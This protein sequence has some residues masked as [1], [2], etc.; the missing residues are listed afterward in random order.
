MLNIYPHYIF[1]NKVLNQITVRKNKLWRYLP[2]NSISLKGIDAIP[3]KEKL[4]VRID[5]MLGAFQK[6]LQEISEKEKKLILEQANEALSHKFV[7]LGSSLTDMNRINWHADFKTGYIWP[8]GVYY[9]KQRLATAPGSDIKV[10][11]E[12]SRFHHLLWLGEAYVLTE[13]DK[14]A[15]EIVAEID[16]W[17]RENPLMYSVNWTCTMDVAIRAVNWL[18]SV[19]MIL[20]S[21][22]VSDTF[23]EKFYKSLYQHGWFIYN[24][25]EKSVP[26]SNN[27]LF[28]D[29]SGLIYLAL[30]FENTK[31]GKKWKKYVVPEFYEEI[32][33]QILPS[34]VQYERSVSY[35]RLMTELAS[36]PCYLLKRIGH[37]IPAD[38]EYRV[39]SMYSFIATYTKD[40]GYAP[41]IEDNDDG[42]FLP[43]LRRDFRFHDYLLDSGSVE[44]RVIAKGVPLFRYEKSNSRLYKDAGHAII[45]KSEAY[46]FVTN[47]GFSKYENDLKEQGSHTHND[48]LSFELSLGM[49]DII[50]DPGAYVYTSDPEKCNEF[51]ST[52]KHNTIVVDG[53]EQNELSRENVFLL[54]KN[55]LTTSFEFETDGACLGGYRTLKQSMSH[56]R[57]LWLKED[58]LIVK[59]KLEKP[60]GGHKAVL[61]FHLSPDVTVQKV[62]D[63]VLIESESYSVTMTF[64]QKESCP[65]VIVEDDTYSPSYGVLV[66]SKTIRIVHNFEESTQIETKIQWQK[67][68]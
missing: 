22:E 57:K 67:K 23:I 64:I 53:E 33:R 2:V 40:N 10:P 42:R 32:R 31:R 61:S 13:E 54:R 35:H 36:Y 4:R 44:N 56:N 21:S 49:D 12:L 68:K 25:L 66:S 19:A 24:N 11:W 3:T 34:G 55:S 39:R 43:F 62:Q 65:H 48:R 7:L 59:D 15:K 8:K 5:E 28:S 30:L 41:L 60:G 14:Y 50:V 17:M 63:R 6:E 46:L 16:D 58:E 51:H 9:Q 45:R 38:I 26:Y 27:H 29:Y 1:W 47:G 52:G 18:Y 20:E 37:Y